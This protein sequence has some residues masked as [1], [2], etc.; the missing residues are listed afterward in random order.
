MKDFNISNVSSN[1]RS[2]LLTKEDKLNKTPELNN[3]SSDVSNF[4]EMSF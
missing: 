1:I 4:N 3:I 2:H